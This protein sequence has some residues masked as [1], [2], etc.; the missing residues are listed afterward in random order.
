MTIGFRLDAIREEAR[1][2]LER[3]IFDYIEGAAGDE[4]TARANHSAFQQFCFL[5]RVLRDVS[6]V[7]SDLKLMNTD[8]SFPL[9]LA[10]TACHKLVEPERGEIST[11]EAAQSCGVPMVLSCMSSI[12]VT[13]VIQANPMAQVWQQLYI[14]KNRSL[15]ESIIKAAHK[16]GVKA[17]MLTVGV[18]QTGH[19]KRDIKNQFKFPVDLMPGISQQEHSSISVGAIAT[20]MLDAS[21]CWEDILWLKEQSDLPIILKG[22]LSSEDAEIACEV[23]VEGIVVSNHGGRQLD[24][25]IPTILALPEITKTVDKRIKII[26]DGGIRQGSDIFKA[27]CLGADAVMIGRPVLWALALKGASSLKAMLNELRQ[28]FHQVMQLC[29]CRDLRDIRSFRRNI[30]FV[31]L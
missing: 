9:M 8:F 1:K 11:S 16:A 25:S 17:L 18:P 20:T 2:V 26:L 14:F 27:Y 4:W 15:T 29:G 30:Q 10:P 21:V 22:I 12:P 6:N 28:D 5:P 3:S 23:G 24:G 13:E 19:R 31:R 7:H